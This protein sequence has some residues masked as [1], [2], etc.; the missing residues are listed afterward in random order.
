MIDIPRSTFNDWLKKFKSGKL[1]LDENL[2]LEDG[3]DNSL[4]L[5]PFID[6]PAD[7]FV[8]DSIGYELENEAVA[9]LISDTQCDDALRVIAAYCSIN[10][11]HEVQDQFTGI[12]DAIRSRRLLKY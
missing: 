7:D 8:G 3:A 10:C 1:I 11:T 5:F 6:G 4:Q 9:P 2:P 12:V